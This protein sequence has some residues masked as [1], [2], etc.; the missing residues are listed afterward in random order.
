M[1]KTNAILSDCKQFNHQV[2]QVTS[3]DIRTEPQRLE[4][5][6]RLLSLSTSAEEHLALINLLTIWPT[7]SNKTTDLEN[8]A[9]KPSNRLL[10]RMI[11]RNLSF[12]DGARMLI[13]HEALTDAD[14]E[15]IRAELENDETE[16]NESKG[17]R[18]LA[19]LKLC[20]ACKAEKI[21]KHFLRFIELDCFTSEL[22]FD[23]LDQYADVLSL[24]E[25][26]GDRELMELLLQ[27]QQYL[28]VVMTPLY[29]LFASYLLN[30][31]SKNVIYEV[32]R[33]LRESGHG[34]EAAKLFADT[35]GFC[36]SYRTL[37]SCV[38]L[39]QKFKD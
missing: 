6:E 17:Q 24:Q 19:Y 2:D 1:Y 12:I 28:A 39:L 29:P 3:D 32:V 25:I 4:L 38:E 11:E 5:L 31:E 27:D 18:Q 22:D 21:L 13:T 10:V 16:W 37:S 26:L 20:L 33:R 7:F 8:P 23:N 36:G 14:I 30:T 34:L 15:S 35:E 9:S